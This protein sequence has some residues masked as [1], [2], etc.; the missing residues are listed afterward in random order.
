MDCDRCPNE[1]TQTVHNFPDRDLIL[2]LAYN[3][4]LC[5]STWR[6]FDMFSKIMFYF[7]KQAK[8]AIVFF[9]DL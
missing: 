2:K 6:A 7:K 4:H 3:V 8:M 9:A 1:V 5:P